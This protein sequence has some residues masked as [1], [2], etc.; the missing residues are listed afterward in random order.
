MLEI[1]IKPTRKPKSRLRPV[2]V[3]SNKKIIPKGDTRKPRWWRVSVGKKFTGTS[4][5]RRFFNSEADANEFIKETEGASRERGKA[6]FDIPKALAVE[7]VQLS[8]QLEPH[9]ASL[10]QA[11]KFY[12]QKAPIAGRKTVSELIPEYLRTKKNE[13]YRRAQEIS[14]NVFAKDFGS[15]PVCSIF[16]PALEDWFASKKWNP[17]N[18]RNYM[19][20][21]SMFFRWTEFKDYAAGNPFDKIL[22]PS[23]ERTPP[24]IFSVEES[25]RILKTA[26][27]NPEVGLLPMYAIGLFSGVRIEELRF[28][29]WEM[30]DWKEGEI[31][32]PGKITKTGMPRNIEIF[33][34]L[35]AA[36][37]GKV[38]RTEGPIVTSINLR[39]RR[40][41]LLT[42]ADVPRKRN[43][44]RHSFASYHAAKYRNPGAL[45]LLMGQETA[46]ILF[47]HYIAAT[48][49][50]DA[51]AFFNL[52][53]PFEPP[54]A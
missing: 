17:L 22:R 19:R 25:R 28:L 23:I 7:A 38:R 15:K 40:E 39:L 2:K 32:L 51:E 53:P 20:D 14:L 35:R 5:L 34:A 3:D 46:S 21:L 16:A 24:E 33:P 10:T 44:L 4:K 42:D 9:G 11:V 41:K 52:R 29:C 47:K 30:I 12:L 26:S 49:R 31:R 50:A 54:K 43:A 6:A 37:T 27:D 48:S 13:D 36:L 18:E 8:K 1:N 45:Q